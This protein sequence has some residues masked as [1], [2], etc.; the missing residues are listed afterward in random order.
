[1]YT[2]HV[3][4]MQSKWEYAE[5]RSKEE[6]VRHM[7]SLTHTEYNKERGKSKI[8]NRVRVPIIINNTKMNKKRKKI[9]HREYIDTAWLAGC[10]AGWLAG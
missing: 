3:R 4:T 1:M 6:A 10:L 9:T 7:H 8:S 5:K 2:I